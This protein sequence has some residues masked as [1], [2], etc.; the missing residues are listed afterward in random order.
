MVSGSRE[1]DSARGLTRLLIQQFRFRYY[2]HGHGCF[3]NVTSFLFIVF[4]FHK[5]FF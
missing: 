5:N 1:H 4:L 2:S 3:T